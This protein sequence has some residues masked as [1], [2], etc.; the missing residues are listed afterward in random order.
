[1]DKR[2]NT[3]Q[4]LGPRANRLISWIYIVNPILNLLNKSTQRVVEHSVLVG[5]MGICRPRKGFSVCGHGFICMNH[6]ISG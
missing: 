3:D 4:S 1:M 5:R 6:V 2:G